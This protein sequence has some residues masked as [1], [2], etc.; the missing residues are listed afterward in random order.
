MMSLV[1][2]LAVTILHIWGKVRPTCVVLRCSM[3]CV[4]AVQQLTMHSSQLASL[5]T[6]NH[7]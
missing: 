1:Y 7:T 3:L 6:A 4:A 5:A 2:I